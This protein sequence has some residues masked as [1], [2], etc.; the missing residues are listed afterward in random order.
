MRSSLRNRTVIHCGRYPEVSTAQGKCAVPRGMGKVSRT[1]T[2][3]KPAVLLTSLAV[4]MPS[5]P[6]KFH[7]RVPMAV[8]H[9][10]PD[11]A[12]SLGIAQH[13]RPVRKKRATPSPA[14]PKAK[15]NVK[16]LKHKRTGLHTRPSPPAL[17][18]TKAIV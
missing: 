4:M 10:H 16:A 13:V 17:G 1:A 8:V 12:V 3:G 18:A 15:A 7:E 11:V 14:K 6:S 9:V 5:P 2:P